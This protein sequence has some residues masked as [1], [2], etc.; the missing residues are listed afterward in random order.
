MGHYAM[1]VARGACPRLRVA[2]IETLE[3]MGNVWLEATM[4]AARQHPAHD[5]LVYFGQH[6]MD[7]ETGHAMGSHQADLEALVLDAGQ[8]AQAEVLVHGLYDRMERFNE[9]ILARA[10]A[11]SAKASANGGLVDI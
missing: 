1:A 2:I 10:R 5:E 7:R 4:V 9:E 6:H 11:A 3:S 8:R